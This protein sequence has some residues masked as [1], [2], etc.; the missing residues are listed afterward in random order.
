VFA[1]LRD[2]GTTTYSSN[3]R[4]EVP[5]KNKPHEY[6]SVPTLP[7]SAV[8]LGVMNAFR[9]RC[10]PALLVLTFGDVFT[11]VVTFSPAPLAALGGYRSAAPCLR[12]PARHSPGLAPAGPRW[13]C[14]VVKSGTNCEK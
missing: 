14:T 12:A 13:R 8:S 10:A 11:R 6:L 5:R 3:S 2:V 1:I 7:L 9:L 4:V